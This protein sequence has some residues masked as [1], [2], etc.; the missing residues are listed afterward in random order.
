MAIPGL[1]AAAGSDKG[2]RFLGGFTDFLTGGM[3]DLD[4][5]GDNRM[6]QFQ[7]NQLDRNI[8]AAKGFADFATG[9]MTDFDKRGD[10]RL[11][12]FQKNQMRRNI[13]GAKGFG[14]FITGGRT[15]FDQKGDSGVQQFG[16]KVT[17]ALNPF[18]GTGSLAKNAMDLVGIN[19]T[20][21]MDTG[22]TSQGAQE[23]AQKVE[24]NEKTGIMQRVADFLNR[25]PFPGSPDD[26][27]TPS[28]SKLIKGPDGEMYDENFIKTIPGGFENMQ[29]IERRRKIFEGMP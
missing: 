10:S 18:G 4:Q 13:E 15:D 21:R 28:G 20:Q 11:Q 3:T 9:G 24:Q 7:K 19:G 23:L 6:Q 14:D 5:K 2:K 12:E 16:K 17:G 8:M 26:P 1:A 27:R 22:E 25:G 29:E